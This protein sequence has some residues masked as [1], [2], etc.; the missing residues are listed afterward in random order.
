MS[1]GLANA[2]AIG[3]V[4]ASTGFGAVYAWTTGAHHGIAL[5]CLMVVMA[6]AL[7]LAKPLSVAAAFAAFR[8]WSIFRGAALAILA[9]V[10]VAYSLTAELSLMATSRGDLA[11]NREASIKAASAIE[12]EAQRARDRYERATAELDALPSTRP[13]SELQAEIDGLLLTPGADECAEINGKVTREV[14]PKVAALRAERARAERR[15][16][17]E[18]ILATPLPSIPQSS[19]QA[20]SKSD[21]AASALS[22]YLSLLGFAVAPAVL[23]EWLVLV[24]VLAL[25]VGS[26]MAGI[27]AQ[28]FAG[29]ARAVQAPAIRKQENEPA[30]VQTRPVQ[31]VHA[32]KTAAAEPVDHTREKVK[33]AIVKQLKVS[34]GSV[35]SGERGLAKLIGANR[36]T[37]RRA[38]NGLVTAGV[39]AAEA[40]RNGTML[41]LIA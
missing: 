16:E 38:I 25:E 23:S 32:E 29:P 21:P 2:A 18:S 17:L 3:L 9:A 1:A 4:I 36:S 22:A 10:A 31:V 39:I 12:D 30:A 19:M 37:M 41:R 5:G 34:G 6:V 13:A 28:S 33:A 24:G 35:S 14:C 8:S 11:A 27:L 20:V 15:T 40:T 7:E 26:A